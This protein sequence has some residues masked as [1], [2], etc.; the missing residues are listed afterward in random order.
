M[1][2]QLSVLV[3]LLG[4]SLLGTPAAPTGEKDK[5]GVI[6]T[7]GEHKLF[8]GNLTVKVYEEG[9]KLTMDVT[10]RLKGQ[11]S[12]THSLPKVLGKE[13][14]FWLIYAQTP[15]K[16]WYFLYPNTVPLMLWEV[17][18]TERGLT[19]STT[20]FGPGD[21]LKNAPRSVR[22]ALPKEVLEKF[23]SK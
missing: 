9:G 6:T 2:K 7:V 11:G 12:F 15:N 14:A 18:E 22:D 21:V 8:D 17:A 4:L 10:H 1:C 3:L 13:G 16:V 19:D 20:G 23:K 5:T